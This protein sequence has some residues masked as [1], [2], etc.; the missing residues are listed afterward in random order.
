MDVQHVKASPIGAK[1]TCSSELRSKEGRRLTFYV[2]ASDDQG[3]IGT[4]THERFIVNGER[5]VDKL[6]AYPFPVREK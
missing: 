1:I 5:F 4:A 6:S 3:V 2:E